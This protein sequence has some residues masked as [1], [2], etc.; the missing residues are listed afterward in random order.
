MNYTQ[1]SLPQPGQ[2]WKFP[3]GDRGTFGFLRVVLRVQD[4]E[5]PTRSP[6]AFVGD[7]ALV[8]VS[9]ETTIS[10]GMFSSSNL[11]FDGT[12]LALDDPWS[13][14]GYELVRMQTVE[15]DAVEFPCWF[16]NI[17]TGEG[18]FRVVFCRGE[19]QVEIPGLD[20]KYV[21]MRWGGP[22]LVR[23]Y[24]AQLSAAVESGPEMSERFRFSDL[25]YHPLKQE[26]I[27]KIGVDLSIPYIALFKRDVDRVRIYQRAVRGES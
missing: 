19:V 6:L 15:V 21:E 25:R 17:S 8:Q 22:S 18:E 23:R 27:E 1:V 9:R 14:D 16:T 20:R 4:L 10:D 7:S 24:P 12:F 2:I 11:L 5:L 26:I 13:D 3:C